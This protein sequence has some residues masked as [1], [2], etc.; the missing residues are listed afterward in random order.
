MTFIPTERAMFFVTILCGLAV[1]IGIVIGAGPLGNPSIGVTIFEGFV[2]ILNPLGMAGLVY[3]G[4][5]SENLVLVIVLYIMGTMVSAY[6]A[7]ILD[8]NLR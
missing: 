7:G 1:P 6:L 5:L 8:A 2:W 4:S 3:G